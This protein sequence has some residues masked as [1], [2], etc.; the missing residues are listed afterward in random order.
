M[1]EQAS[2]SIKEILAPI[3]GHLKRVEELVMENMETDI[4]LLTEVGQYILSS[5][6]KR[7]RPAML[8][9][10]VGCLGEI[11]ER[12]C[13]TANIV[14]YIHTATLL[15]DDVVDNADLRRS[16]QS[17]R[18]IWGNEASVLVGDYLFTVSFK[19]LAAMESMELVHSL[20]R[21]TTMMARG[22]IFQLVRS[23]ESATEEDY[24]EIVLHKT[25]SL[26]GAAME[27]GGI[28]AGAGKAQQ[29]ALYECGK[30]VGIAFQMVDDALDYRLENDIGKA[31]GTDLKERKITL[32]LSHLLESASTEDQERVLDILDE[33]EI[34]DDHVT[35]VA[36]LIQKYGSVDYTLQRAQ[37]YVD[38]AK[39][40][41]SIL[42]ENRYRQGLEQLADF[43]VRRNL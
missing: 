30:C 34:T 15:H 42:P 28:L 40:S 4:P 13:Q 19:H 16:K 6:G 37:E 12:A 8:L 43:V 31:Q 18:S 21:S 22:E 7:V 38:Q 41:L 24:I 29:D 20:S 1:S 10:A 14:E 2:I 9:F 17:A 5:G 36:G 11:D 25:A 23:N 39:A 3:E 33:D 26:M 27:M 32:P 35:E